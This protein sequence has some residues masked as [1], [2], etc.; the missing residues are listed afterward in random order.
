MAILVTGGTGFTGSNIV[1]ELVEQGNKVISLDIVPPDDLLTRYLAPWANNVIWMTGDTVDRATTE[2]VSAYYEI[3]KIVH[4]AT[5]STYGNLETDNGRRV[6]DVNLQ[7]T[8]NA[9][10]IA[11]RLKVKRFIF[12]S[13]A[14]VYYGRPTSDQPLRED[15]PLSPEAYPLSAP[16]FY[17][18]TKLAGELLTQR[19][20]HLYGFDTAS[21]RMSQNWGPIE[22]VT[23][24]H[25]R[26]S[27]PNQWAGKAVRGEP[28]EASPYG[29]GI[30]EG[31]SF[32][33]DHC[34]V[35]DT[36]AAVR[37]MLDA[38]SLS[39]PVYNISTG[40]PLSLHDMVAAIREA[41]PSVKFVEPIPTEDPTKARSRHLDTTRMRE[42]LGFVPKYDMASGLKD[43]IEWRQTFN[44][45]D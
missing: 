44:F 29:S 5:Y 42:D 38:A 15:A 33:T 40:H 27:L 10:D 9:L 31:R 17:C 20:G 26:V 23:P 35:K 37:V 1:K 18:I 14:A 41:H 22:R 24:Y 4:V 32:G 36:A 6:C 7:G 45:M 3:D 19:Y 39:Y 8:L 2:A 43:F 25:S 30:T 21:V 34:Y 11:R 16:G 12:I 28:I 13:S